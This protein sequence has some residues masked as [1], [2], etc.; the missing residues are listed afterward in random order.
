MQGKVLWN[1]VYAQWRQVALLLFVVAPVIAAASLLTASLTS[2]LGWYAAAALAAAALALAVA[3]LLLLLARRRAAREQAFL[4]AIVASSSDAIVGR[5]L[6]GRIL[7]WNAGAERMFGYTAAEAIGQ[8]AALIVPPDRLDELVQD[9][10]RVAQLPALQVLETQRLAKDGS[11]IDVSISVFHVHAAGGTLIGV[12]VIMHDIREGKRAEAALRKSQEKLQSLFD[13]LPVGVSIVDAA[14]RVQ[15]TNPVLAQIL[16]LT[17]EGILRGAYAQRRYFRPDCTPMPPAEFPSQR[18]IREQRTIRDVEIGVEK[19]D[20]TVIWTSVSATPLSPSGQSA[21][22]TV[23]ITERKQAEDALRLSEARLRAIIE[24]TRNMIWSV[25]HAYHLVIANAVFD[26]VTAAQIG[27]PLVAGESVLHPTYPAAVNAFW[28]AQYDRALAGES[29]V[30]EMASHATRGGTLECHMNPIRDPG[31]TVVGAAGLTIDITQQKMAQQLL[32][33]TNAE[34]ERRVAARTAELQET[35]AALHRANAGKDAFM[36]VVSH[37]LRTPLTGILTMSEV[38]QSPGR[39]ALTPRQARYVAMIRASGE[40][41]LETVNSVLLYTSLAGGKYTVQYAQCPLAD[42]CA[43]SVQALRAQADAK[44]QCVEL[45]TD[46]DTMAADLV[47]WSDPAALAKILHVLLDNAVKFTPAGGAIGVDVRRSP[48]GDAVCLS[49]WDTGIG[50]S[51]EKQANLF[52]PFTQVDQTLARPFE[53]TGIGLAS[54]HRLV[55]LLGGRIA[56]ASEPGEG[57]RFTVTLP[58]APAGI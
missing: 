14:D 27:R 58:V 32:Q 7:S 28:Q 38:L 36:A 20:G 25:D 23:D 29:F 52:D 48:T 56:V 51:L 35:I 26:R 34:L 24:N 5:D 16:H 6:D 10:D 11:L 3:A 46:P 47:I 21:T 37:E 13:V 15:D 41:L 9:A 30:V 2:Q 50:I 55:T 22:V 40:R 18:A 8:P 54:A 49:V 42:I 44:S 57:A 45:D 33:D 1:H 43:E 4:S 39:D 17:P 53:G 31:G 19:E 12:G